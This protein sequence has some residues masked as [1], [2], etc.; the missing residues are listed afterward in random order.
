MRTTESAI[1]TLKQLIKLELEKGSE[2]NA[3]FLRLAY[4]EIEL[5]ETYR[6]IELLEIRK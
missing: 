2:R 4:R 1:Q 3:E 6:E 5:L